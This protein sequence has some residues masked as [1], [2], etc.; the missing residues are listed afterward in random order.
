M[1]RSYFTIT[2]WDSDFGH[3]MINYI[4]SDICSVINEMPVWFH[5]HM[6]VKK[7]HCL[8]GTKFS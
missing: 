7:I 3:V 6:L 4:F 1:I 5:N 8:G 2:D